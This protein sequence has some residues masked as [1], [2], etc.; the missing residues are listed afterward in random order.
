MIYS[1]AVTTQIACWL[2]D[3]TSLACIPA[4]QVVGGCGDVI[5]GSRVAPPSCLRLLEPVTL[6][7]QL[8]N[9][10]MMREAI[11]KRAGQTLIAED[12]RP[13][14]EWKIRRDD[15]RA[16][17]QTACRDP[18]PRVRRNY[19]DAGLYNHLSRLWAFSE[20]SRPEGRPHAC[21]VGM[22][23]MRRPPAQSQ[24]QIKSPSPIP[25]K[26]DILLVAHVVAADPTEIPARETTPSN[27][28]MRG[29]EQWISSPR[30][31]LIRPS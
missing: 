18:C 11:E 27:A 1:S 24:I 19:Y 17:A 20:K 7:I 10:D 5:G 13:F 8:Q 6:A 9:M 12:A 2:K 21:Q 23:K 26:P 25:G 16:T 29:E 15:G 31:G 22:L 3:P 28:L 14:L 30:K 4:K